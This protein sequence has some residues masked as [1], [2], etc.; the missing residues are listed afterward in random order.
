MEQPTETPSAGEDIGNIQP[1]NDDD[2]DGDDQNSRPGVVVIVTEAEATMTAQKLND[3]N[4]LISRVSASLAELETKLLDLNV[5]GPDPSRWLLSMTTP[6][7][8]NDPEQVE[9]WSNAAAA[10]A[11]KENIKVRVYFFSPHDSSLKG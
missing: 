11:R 3:G 6:S 9:V 2:G 4:G 8:E 10:Q 7:S 1:G 5:G